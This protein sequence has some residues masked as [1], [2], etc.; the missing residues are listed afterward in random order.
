MDKEKFKQFLN[1]YEDLDKLTREAFYKFRKAN[2][3]SLNMSNNSYYGG[4]D[5]DDCDNDKIAIRYSDSYNYETLVIPINALFGDI[6]SYIEFLICRRDEKAAEVKKKIEKQKLE[7]DRK[8]YERLKK[9]F[10]K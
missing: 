7:K 8:E 3:L 6:D 5:V 4:I 9:I 1:F 2:L 10:D